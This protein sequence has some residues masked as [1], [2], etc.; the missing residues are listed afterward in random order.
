MKS[1]LIAGTIILITGIVTVGC[2]PT[3]RKQL[4][5]GERKV[6]GAKVEVTYQGSAAPAANLL[7]VALVNCNNRDVEVNEATSSTIV[8]EHR[9]LIDGAACV[10]EMHIGKQ[11]W[12]TARSFSLSLK[13]KFLIGTAEL[14][15]SEETATVAP[16]SNNVNVNIAEIKN[17][18]NF[19]LSSSQCLDR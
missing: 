18:S 2:G 5:I 4:E 3:R 10:L 1:S 16:T 11:Q 8:L 13:D 12:K 6:V 15:L 14:V 7:P 17:C 19:D 9:G